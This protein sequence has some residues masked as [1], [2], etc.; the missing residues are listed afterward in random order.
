[1]RIWPVG[2][3]SESRRGHVTAHHVAL[4]A[5]GRG[6]SLGRSGFG[7]GSPE[8]A[9]NPVCGV[10]TVPRMARRPRA[11]PN[12]LLLSRVSQSPEKAIMETGRTPKAL[13][14]QAGRICRRAAHSRIPLR[15]DIVATEVLIRPEFVTSD[16]DRASNFFLA[17]NGIELPRVASF[18]QRALG[19]ANVRSPIDQFLALRTRAAPNARTAPSRS[20]I[21]SRSR[22]SENLIPRG[23][24]LHP[25]GQRS[26]ESSPCLVS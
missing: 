22:W 23:N 9:R 8:T 4:L 15:P 26:L 18:N 1:M 14:E 3:Q 7:S 21:T 10:I 20:A 17:L 6:W 2:E 11:Q 24:R 16:P 5:A 19:R 13:S 12:G 25:S